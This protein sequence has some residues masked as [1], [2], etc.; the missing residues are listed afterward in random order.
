MQTNWPTGPLVLVGGG[1]LGL[2]LAL[3]LSPVRDDVHLLVRNPDRR[4]AI[5]AGWPHL[6]LLDTMTSLPDASAVWLLVPDQ[7]LEAAAA[8]LAAEVAAGIRWPPALVLHSA[9]AMAAR[10][11]A[12][13]TQPDLWTCAS[14][15]PLCAVPDPLVQRRQGQDPTSPLHGALFAVDGPEALVPPLFA[16]AQALGG[17][18]VVVPPDVR[19]VYHA[20]AALVAN[21]LVALLL[22]GESLLNGIGLPQA[23]SR[24]GLVHLAQSSLQAVAAVPEDKPWVRGLT[25][26]VARGDAQTLQRHLT[27]LDQQEGN[28]ADS[29]ASIHRALSAALAAA[30]ARAGLHTLQQTQQVATVLSPNPSSTP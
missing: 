12:A 28:G 20:A 6:N 1:R 11:V 24:A 25:G 8:A 23:T 16:L 9:G 30:L 7:V 17:L 13:P 5:A 29:A 3:A 18:P 21:D 15:H 22:A 27:V 26:A 2:T 19:A 10:A 4:A 14:L